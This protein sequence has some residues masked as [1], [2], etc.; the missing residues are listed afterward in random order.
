MPPYYFIALLIFF[1]SST[2]VQI[3]LATALSILAFPAWLINASFIPVHGYM[4][5][6]AIVLAKDFRKELTTKTCQSMLQ[7][8]TKAS[9]IAP[10]WLLIRR[11]YFVQSV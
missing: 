8:L 9:I 11:R 4:L 3:V 10:A 7:K 1:I 5:V 2:A 6:S